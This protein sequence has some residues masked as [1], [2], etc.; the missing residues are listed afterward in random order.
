M[1][2]PSP[3]END[4]SP[5]L[6]L[7]G[8][9][10]RFLHFLRS[11]WWIVVGA[12]ALGLLGQWTYNHFW[13]PP[14]RAVSRM[15]VGGK[16]KIPEG[17]LYAEEW[18][19]FFGTQ[20][21]LM[22]GEKIRRRTLDRL[23]RLKQNHNESPVKIEVN[24][25]RKTTI[26]VLLA[27]GKDPTYTVNYLNALMDEYLS[28]RKEVRSLSSDDTLASLTAQFLEQEKELKKQQE[29]ILA[30]QKTNSLAI[31]REQSSSAN[32]TKLSSELGDLTLQRALLVESLDAPAAKDGPGDS[33]PL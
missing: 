9:A 10:Q 18:Q 29:G 12:V 13:P 4:D 19:N 1:L 23:Q 21:E 30:F 33:R 31:L 2:M 28:Y 6:A 22:Q 14:A 15:L 20:A 26:F 32:L 3:S 7:V 17:G 8:R 5:L 24:Q 25:I 11:R 27:T 16:I